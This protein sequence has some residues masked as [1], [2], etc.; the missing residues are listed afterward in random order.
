LLS[1]L[2]PR[3]RPYVVV[4]RAGTIEAKGTVFSVHVA[5]PERTVVVL[6]EGRVWLKSV[7]GQTHLLVAPARAVLEGDIHVDRAAPPS[8]PSDPADGADALDRELLTLSKLDAAIPSQSEPLVQLGPP[9]TESARPSTSHVPRPSASELLRQAQ[10]ARAL[11]QGTSA[12]R[13]YDQL[14]TAYPQTDEARVSLV[15]LGEFELSELQH[16]HS[17]LTYFDRYLAHGGPLT[18]EAHYGKIRALS[19]LHRTEE[20]KAEAARFVSDYPKSVQADAIRRSFA[21]P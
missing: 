8:N 4:T 14:I 5:S 21:L 12:Q 15:S 13:L 7:T 20:A 1:R 3:A 10:R 19:A 9:P 11:G 6:H 2:E 16:P 17:A 18:R